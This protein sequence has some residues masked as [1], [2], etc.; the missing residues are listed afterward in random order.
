MARLGLPYRLKNRP[1]YHSSVRPVPCEK[2]TDSGPY[3]SAR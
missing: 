2:M 1:S 3:S